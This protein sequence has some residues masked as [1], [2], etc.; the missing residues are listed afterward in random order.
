MP[1][2]RLRATHPDHV[3]ALAFQFDQA[4]DLRTLKLLNITDEFTKEA[5]AIHVDH[6][7]AGGATVAVLELLTFTGCIPEFIRMDNGTKLEVQILSELF[8]ID[9][10]EDRLNRAG[11]SPGLRR[12]VHRCPL[13]DFGRLSWPSPIPHMLGSLTFRVTPKPS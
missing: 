13:Q 12:K 4:S 9:Y 1:A 2:K 11:E 10:N 6:S 7:I 3:W 8:R 5:L